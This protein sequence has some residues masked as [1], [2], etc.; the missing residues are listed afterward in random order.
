MEELF[1]GKEKV[2]LLERCPQFKERRSTVEVR[3]TKPD[4]KLIT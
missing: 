2:P 4:G 3:Q 1:L